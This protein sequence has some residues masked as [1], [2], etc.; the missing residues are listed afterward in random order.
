MTEP[1]IFELGSPGRRGCTLPEW[2]IP[3]RPSTTH[4]PER[5]LRK[6]A[7]SLPEVSELDVVRHYTA[8][9]QKNFS[10][11]THFYPLG[12]CTMKYNPKVNED[13][14]REV[15]FQSIHPY[16]NE[17]T[18]QGVLKILYDLE[19]LLCEIV[20][21]DAFSLQPAAGAQGEMTGLLIIHAYHTDRKSPRKKIIVPDSSHGTNPA[22]AALCG[23]QVLQVKSNAQ[24][25][26][27]LEA[28]KCAVDSDVAGM[29]LTNPNTLGLFEDEVLEIARLIH[30][31]GGLLYYD[32]ANL[33]PLLGMAR[34]GDMGFDIVHVNVHKTFSTPH[35]G[36]GPGAGPVGVKQFL[37]KYLPTPRLVKDKDALRLKSDFPKSVGKLNAFYG[38]VG[39]LLRAYAYIRA[40][41]KEGL[42]K[43]GQHAI[44]N[45]N[46]L[47][48][49]LESFYEVPY[50]GM[51]MHEFVLS[52]SRQKEKGVRALD[53][54][55][56]LIDFG[57][58]PPTV[59]FPLIVPEALMIEPTETESRQTLDRFVSVMKQMA[60]DA[61]V[62]PELFHK[63]PAAASVCRLDE[64]SAARNPIVKWEK[65]PHDASRLVADS[66]SDR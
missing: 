44:L 40:L 21:V 20:G 1:L 22:S 64:V 17:E 25:R 3:R 42:L 45:A 15:G 29:M 26:V 63:A 19:K 2:D 50:P 39:V 48:K 51:C 34:P 5:L 30:A 49:N 66:A 11:D 33:N 12:S 41:G 27:D 7:P 53:I 58:H 47:L 62:R 18:V 59:Y 38:N 16:Q 46:Y 60:E 9:S 37:A 8:L 52:G 28:L 36:G 57:I 13:V 4:L 6:T 65:K 61:K 32:G 14:V 43:T 54:A 35:G 23:Y 31:S 56:R 24:G 10:V 55:K